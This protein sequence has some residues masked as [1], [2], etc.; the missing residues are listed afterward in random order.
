[1]KNNKAIQQEHL[2]RV[3]DTF[4]SV[5]I[6]SDSKMLPIEVSL[7]AQLGH[8][9]GNH[10]YE[11]IALRQKC[12]IDFVDE[13]EEP[14]AKLAG[15]NYLLGDTTSLYS[16]IV[17][18]T[19]HPFHKHAGHRIFT[20]VS[21]SGGAQLRFSTA[22]AED[23]KLNP[24]KFI[25]KLHFINIPPDCLFTVRFG[26]DTWHQFW[27]LSKN[28]RHPV[29]FAL[30]CHTDELGGNLS[31][32]MKDKIIANK[33]DIP[34]L[35]EVLPAEIA[36]HMQSSAYQE[37]MVK[38]TTLALDAAAG[39]FHRKVCDTFRGTV[40]VFRGIW[41]GWYKSS[42][43]VSQTNA[44]KMVK[45]FKTLP[46]NSLLLEHLSNEFVNH[47]DTFSITVNANHFEGANPGQLLEIMLKG[48]LNNSPKGVSK[49][50]MLR[51]VIVK[52][53]GLRTS[54]L[55]C[56]VSSLLSEDT[57]NLYANKYPVLNQRSNE[58]GTITQVI[59]GA[60]DKH[61]KFRS[62]IRVE[63]INDSHIMFSLDN[64]VH[65]KNLFGRFYMTVIDLVH[66]HYIAPVMLRRSVD[67]VIAQMEPVNKVV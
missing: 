47:E 31:E 51:N 37:Q 30:S 14:S 60:N 62:C 63:V 12:H 13:L 35:T 19:G 34:S 39:T 59:L 54:P 25:D 46:A 18:P 23:I 10:L 7:I 4:P 36:E 38:T 57:T 40:G 33:A 27:P 11:S 66:R 41:G 2:T 28:T 55:G 43:Y 61:L 15:T 50:M 5:H 52:P 8:G 21:G 65:C 44:T 58:A 32:E 45:A 49:L 67:Y 53:F 20:A 42:G 48:F 64:R 3:I 17:G 6:T 1:M 24:L 22:T 26:G 16:F 29:F 56:P 9:A